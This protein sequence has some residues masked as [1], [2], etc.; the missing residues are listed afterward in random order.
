[1]AFCLSPVF[2]GIFFRERGFGPVFLFYS[3]VEIFYNGK[4]TAC[5]FLF[6]C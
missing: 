2:C 4:M 1:M 6:A 3:L 5:F